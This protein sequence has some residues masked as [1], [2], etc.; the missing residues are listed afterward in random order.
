MNGNKTYL[1]GDVLVDGDRG[2]D[3]TSL[4]EEGADG[5]SRSLGGD[6]DDI[7]VL[8]RDHT[9]VLLVDNREA[10]GEVQ[11]LALGLLRCNRRFRCGSS[12]FR[13]VFVT[14]DEGRDLRPGLGLCGIRQ[15]VHDDGTTV[16]S[17]LNREESLS[18]NLYTEEARSANVTCGRG[19]T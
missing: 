4:L 17:L 14:H 19:L 15:Q 2:V 5:T 18:G 6:E 8:G 1:A 3:T 11:G 9:G 10:V 13:V 12:S 7:D 16:D